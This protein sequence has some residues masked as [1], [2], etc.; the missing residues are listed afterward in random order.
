[1]AWPGEAWHGKAWLGMA[2]PGAA[3][4]GEAWPGAAW[5]GEAWPGEA[6][7]GLKVGRTSKL[8]IIKMVKWI[9]PHCKKIIVEDESKVE[10]NGSKYVQCPYCGE[11]CLKRAST[12]F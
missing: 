4:Q 11:F 5:Q 3:W 12:A 7:Q 2:R 9:C 8:P 10:E 1:M 6:R